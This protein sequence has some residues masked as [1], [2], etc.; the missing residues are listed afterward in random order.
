M[1]MQVNLD[2]ISDRNTNL[3]K[4]SRKGNTTP[5]GAIDLSSV[6]ESQ[7]TTLLES[8][9]SGSTHA[10]LSSGPWL[11]CVVFVK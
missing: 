7:L 10:I 1:N 2:N 8:I 9:A 5:T 11:A 3:M 4:L 6:D